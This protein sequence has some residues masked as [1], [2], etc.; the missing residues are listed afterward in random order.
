MKRMIKRFSALLL[1]AV[2]IC[3]MGLTALAGAPTTPVTILFTHD[4]HSH[5][6]PSAGEDGG[7]YGG[8]ARLM[9]VI[10]EQKEKYPDALLVDGGDFSM[11]SL[12]QTAYATSALELRMMG[13][14]GY[15]AT[16][17]GN[18]E[19]DYL[20]AGLASMLNVAADCGEPVPAIVDANY[21]PPKE[22]EA[23]YG[24]DAQ[25]VWDALENYGVKDYM[26]LERG[27]VY[28][29]LFGLTGVNSDE[30]APNSGMILEDPAQ[31]AQ[32]IVD[33]ARAECWDTYGCQPLVI[34]LSH[35]GTSNGEGEDYE[36]AQKVEGIDLIVSAHTHTTLTEPIQVNDTWI[37]SAGEYGKYLGVVQMDYKPNGEMLLTGYELIPID[38]NVEEDPEIAALV[39]SY[40]T[41]VEENYLADYGMSFDQV[42]TSNSYEFDDVDAVY[43]YAHESTLGNVFSDAYLWAVEQATGETVDVALTASGVIRESIPVGDVTVSDIF[44]AASLGVGTEGELIAIY[45]TGADLKNALEVDASVY[46]LMHSAQLFFSGVEYSYNTNR[47]IFNKVDYAML[48]RGEGKLEA[49]EDKRM[50]RVVCGMYMGQMLGSVESTSM[51]LLTITPRDVYGDP[52]A[53]SDLG[54]YV[55]RD[56]DGVPVKEWYAIASY[57]DQMGG[58]MDERYAEA[59]GRK[60]VY[61]SWNPITLLRSAN[62]FT[63]ILL[64]VILALMALVV[65]IVRAAVRRARKRR[66]A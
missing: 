1:A 60:D 25:A 51:G 20:P 45:L 64:A 9:T 18:H 2:L 62:R 32:R 49:I 39:E 13:A 34:A 61:S 22:G 52:I 12:F 21:L 30:C 57:L 58:E 46:P 65:L 16:T 17:F 38:E 55:V 31:T 8:Y 4:L 3:S 14:M 50:Y 33:E 41:E 23:G 56:A 37:V 10:R 28:Y 53:V 15:D 42:L 27:G 24:P 5:L 7:E 40:K 29:A 43:G 63:Y 19:F 36:L 66:G 35:S 47:M 54:N 44:N 59:D 26:I 11:G 48:R 6:L